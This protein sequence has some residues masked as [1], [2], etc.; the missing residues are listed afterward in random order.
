MNSNRD[1]CDFYEKCDF[2]LTGTT[3][4]E[5]ILKFNYSQINHCSHNKPPQFKNGQQLYYS[6]IFLPQILQF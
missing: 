6:I 5:L 2:Q 3:H 1:L 4:Q